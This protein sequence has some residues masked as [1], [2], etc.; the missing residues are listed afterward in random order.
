MQKPFV[1]VE[2][3]MSARVGTEVVARSAVE[4]VADEVAAAARALRLVGL[5]ARVEALGAVAVVPA[6]QL[7]A[8]LHAARAAVVGVGMNVGLAAVARA[9]LVE[10][11]VAVAEP[12]LALDPVAS[13]N[14][15]P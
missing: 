9:A 6:F 13:L 2:A 14:A 15:Q 1:Q 7:R 12:A 8:A 4:A 5:R 11:V 3:L 10:V